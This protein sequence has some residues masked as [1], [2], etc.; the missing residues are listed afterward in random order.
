MQFA[1]TRPI[2]PSLLIFV[3]FLVL[4]DGARGQDITSNLAAHWKLNESSGTSAADSSGNGRTGTVFGT[5]SWLAGLI[6]NCTYLNSATYVR[7]TGLMGNPVNVTVAAWVN[8]SAADT[9]G[10]EV[11]SLGDC[12]ILRLDEG[13]TTLKGIVYKGSS[14]WDSVSSTRTFAGT[15]WHHVAAVFSDSSNFLRLYVDG[16]QVAS[17]SSYGA[18]VYSGLGTNTYI[19][20]HGNGQ[21]AFDFAGK[22]D[23]A[24]VYSRALSSSDIAALYTD[25]WATKSLLLVHD[26]TSL[27]SQ[28]VLRRD[29]VMEW[30]YKVTQV[31]DSSAQA[32]Y[33][34]ALGDVDVAYVP[35]EIITTDVAYKLRE[36]TVGVVIEEN[37]LQDEFGISTSAGAEST[38]TAVNITNNTQYITSTFSTGSLTITSS[39]QPLTYTNVTRASGFT[40][41]GTVASNPS[42]GVIESGATLANSYNSSNVAF[43]RRVTLPFG[44]SAFDFAALNSNG[45]TLVQ[46]ALAWAATPPGGT[47]GLLGRWKLSEVSGTTAN[48]SS[49]QGNNGTYTNGVTLNAAGPYSCSSSDT[50]ADFDGVNDYVSIA[51]EINFDVTN[52]ITV[53]AWFKVDTFTKNFQALLCKG[54]TAWRIQREGTTNQLQFA[55]SGLSTNKVV[56]TTNVNDGEWHHVVGRFDGSTLSI[57]IDGV[58]EAS[59][60]VTGTITTNNYNVSIG[61][62]LEST[63]RQWDGKVY[64]IYVFNYALSSSQISSLASGT[65]GVWKFSEGTGTTAADTSGSGNNATLS[66]G[67]TWTSDCG[68]V[69]ALS[70]NGTGGKAATTSVFSPPDEGSVAFWMKSNGPLSA[71]GRLFGLGNA[72][73]VR[74]DTAGYLTF[75]VGVASATNFVTSQPLNEAGR[76]YHVVATYSATDDT[77]AIYID[78]Q[79]T[80][81]GTETSGITSQTATI[82]T[83]GTRTGISTDYWPGAIRDFRV[84]SRR[85]CLS[86]VAQLY[87]A[88]GYW[89]LNET[90]GTAAAESSS[91]GA[92]G[93][94]TNGVTL[95]SSGPVSGSY[96]AQ[97]DGTNDYVSL[98]SDS[99]SYTNGMTIAV[100][101]RPTAAGSG[102]RF[103]DAGVAQDSYNILLG[104]QS[105][106]T[107][108]EFAVYGS[109]S[110]TKKYVRASNAIVLNAWHHYAATINSSGVAKLYRDGTELTISS[111]STGYPTIGVPAT[112]TRSSNFVGRSNWAVDEYYQGKMYD[113]R[114][115]NRCLCPSEIL[116][117]YES[118]EPFTGVKIIEWV[119]I[120]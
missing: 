92:S 63:G 27:T 94:Y 29:K 61:E 66:G 114:V 12:I 75:D 20:R 72:W 39:S 38:G 44:G 73:E 71:L 97:F 76:W 16:V 96:A 46:R 107:T 49:G 24:R 37:G 58:Q 55:C 64:D 118:G 88:V 21:T 14:T 41:L 87:G 3:V 69:K 34:S 53:A 23:D 59:T 22:I 35:E 99:S 31:Q 52:A 47:T 98:P 17:V 100:W 82:L 85:L 102:A 79:L 115:Y 67:A 91:A 15:G 8:L 95:G 109:G 119:E 113:A 26:G 70:T 1:T 86:E 111:G 25:G 18:A 5:A 2:R 83:F 9:S 93:T 33:D 77:Y 48:D 54:N 6:S 84:Y 7:A 36:A 43:G 28:E 19:G 110:S 57:Y 78:G 103:V 101:A 30:G 51:N 56:C 81:S 40:S 120:Q 104:R 112:I 11:I 117:I 89:T 32:T 10:A 45:Q 74:Q 13:G 65:G 42:L 50:A 105:T 4:G 116:A 80:N 106:T 108:L 62:N 68:G 60:S 90:S